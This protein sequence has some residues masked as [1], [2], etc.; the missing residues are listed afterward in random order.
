M[1]VEFKQVVDLLEE[2]RTETYGPNT[3]TIGRLGDNTVV[4]QQCGIGKVNAATGVTNLIN[5]YKPDCVLSTGCAGG[6]DKVLRVADV[7]V[8]SE[9]CYH[10]VYCG[11]GVELGQ[12][13]GLPQRFKGDERLLKIAT[14]LES[15]VR[16]VAGLI[17]SGDRFV[18]DREELNVI[19]STYSDGL[20]VDM[21]SA[22]IAHVCYLY[23]VPFL[24]FR[25]ISDT[26]GADEHFQQY[27]NFWDTMA[28]KSFTITRS[29]LTSL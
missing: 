7:V 28:E 5:Q 3:F 17:C 22:A 29:F 13:Q 20:A 24:S 11:E 9:T 8:S 16:V 21:E 1:S 19:K 6:I 25:V 23:N 26:P 14:S 15:D 10:D 4:L 2:T 12:V 27:L 18:T